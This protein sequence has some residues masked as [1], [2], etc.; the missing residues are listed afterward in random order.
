MAS[1]AIALF[2][3]PDTALAAARR[4]K[5][6]GFAALDLISPIPI[7][8]IEEA[9]GKKRSVIKRF[10]FFGALFG[11]LS[12]FALAA[13]TAV[14]YLHPTGGRPIIPFPPYL[15]IAYEMTILCGI[16]ATVLG[17]L[18]SARLPVVRERVYVPEAAVDKFAVTVTCE[19]ADHAQRAAAI[20]REA[21]GEVV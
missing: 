6:A 7:H 2:G 20:L 16:L 13:G 4:L 15:I 5:G 19:S 14:L 21:G 10:T 3:D 18:I 11:G 17:F 1:N 9:L 12:G 8:G